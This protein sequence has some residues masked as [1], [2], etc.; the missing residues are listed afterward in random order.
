M[1]SGWSAA[2][3]ESAEIASASAAIWKRDFNIG[4]TLQVA[5]KFSVKKSIEQY[6]REDNERPTGCKIASVTS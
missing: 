3:A 2:L 5:N 6:H 1:V 4:Q